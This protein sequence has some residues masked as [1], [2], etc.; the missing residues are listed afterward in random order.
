MHWGVNFIFTAFRKRNGLGLPSSKSSLKGA[1]VHPFG[2]FM[3]L[4]RHLEG[5]LEAY[6][7]RVRLNAGQ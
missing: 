5:L 4:V 1:Q 6:F 2:L 7:T 3:G